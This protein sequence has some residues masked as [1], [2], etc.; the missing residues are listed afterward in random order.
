MK[1]DIIA[2][3]PYSYSANTYHGMIQEMISE[4]YYVVD[5]VDL[6]KGIFQPKDIDAIYLNWIEDIMNEDD[7]NL[8]LD[9]IA[10]GVKVYWVFHNRV[11][12][13]RI[14]EKLCRE[15][16]VFL[17]QN[18]SAVIVLSMKSINYLYEYCPDLVESKVH[19]LPHQ[20]YIGNYGVLEDKELKNY[21][22]TE[23]FVFGC[24]GN[25][26]PDKNIELLIR[27]FKRFS[28]NQN[29][30][31]LIVGGADN[32]EYL[33]SLK[34]LKGNNT[35]ILIIPNRIP[36]Y[37]MNFYVQL[38]DVV[39]LPYDLKS[40]MNSGVMLLAFSNARTVISSNISMAEE[41]SDKLIYKY[42]YLDEDDHIKK[43][44]RQMEIAYTDGKESVKRK[45]MLLY[46]E[47]NNKNSKEL[48]KSKLYEILGDF[49][50][51]QNQSEER[52]KL[53]KEYRDKD[54]WRMRYVMADTWLRNVLSE[55]NFIDK[56]KENSTK[57]VAIYGY[58]KYGKMLYSELLRKGVPVTCII[59]QKA[60]NIHEGVSVVTL[61]NVKEKLDIVIVTTVLADV[62][63]VKRHCCKLNGSC[64]VISLKD[65]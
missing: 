5:Y 50:L 17:I 49:S 48:V 12:H 47:V 27:A 52:E 11:S 6:K 10:I 40:C 1:A 59:D 41:F 34:R 32:Q 20:E 18:V 13:D 57:R 33:K 38:I 16:I 25:M 24:L 9:S 56:L 3:Y 22:C 29:C 46:E 14:K 4:R 53:L 55:N 7:K 8:I 39:L 61:D 54:I 63:L 58:G 28:N 23:K 64:Y 51:N 45:G 62:N 36:D 35:N 60:D 31:L 2:F 42:T 15:N 26:R 37:M 43:I 44:S 19:F 30:N 65:I 21:L